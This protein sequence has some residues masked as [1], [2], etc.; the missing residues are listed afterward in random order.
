MRGRQRIDVDALDGIIHRHVALVH[1]AVEHIAHAADGIGKQA[2]FLFAHLMR[3]VKRAD[4][5]DSHR[6][7]H[8]HRT[9]FRIHIARFHGVEGGGNFAHHL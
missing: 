6:V 4:L 3:A 8:R 5:I 7:L 2:V 9:E 1:A